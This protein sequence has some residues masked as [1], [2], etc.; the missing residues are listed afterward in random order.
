LL[1]RFDGINGFDQNPDLNHIS[2]FPVIGLG[3]EARGDDN[4]LGVF[5]NYKA[6]GHRIPP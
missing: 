4:P 5:V 1:D 6:V 3:G 2:G